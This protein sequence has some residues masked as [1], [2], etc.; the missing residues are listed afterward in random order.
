A[1]PGLREDHIISALVTIALR[2]LDDKWS[3]AAVLTSITHRQEKFLQQFL[4]AKPH[5]ESLPLMMQ[6]LA[7]IGAA[8]APAERLTEI[9]SEILRSNDAEDL[10]WQMAAAA[11]FGDGLRAR[12][13]PKGWTPSGSAL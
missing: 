9:L 1:K 10:S 11:G 7:R 6:E 5:S 2:D 13:H 3:R 8:E 12:E 4:A